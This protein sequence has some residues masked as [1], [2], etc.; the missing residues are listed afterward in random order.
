LRNCCYDLRKK[1]ERDGEATSKRRRL[2]PDASSAGAGMPAENPNSALGAW[3]MRA[4]WKA[5]CAI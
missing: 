1:H 2:P 3:R 5:R 4:R